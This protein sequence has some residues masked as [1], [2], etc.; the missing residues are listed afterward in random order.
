MSF[1]RQHFPANDRIFQLFVFS[2]LNGRGCYASPER[3]H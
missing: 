3:V 2:L 1:M